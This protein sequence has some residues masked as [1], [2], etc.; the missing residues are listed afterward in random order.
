[1]PPLLARKWGV[2]DEPTVLWAV[3][4]H[5]EGPEL[6]L[7]CFECSNL[8]RVLSCGLRV[9]SEWDDLVVVEHVIPLCLIHAKHD[10]LFRRRVHHLA[11]L[12]KEHKRHE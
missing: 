12:R 1:M 10:R 4:D 11:E 7:E 8:A 6:R 3:I 5:V 2:M 9:M